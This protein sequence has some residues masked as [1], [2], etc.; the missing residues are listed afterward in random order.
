MKTN[1][2]GV[3]ARVKVAAGDLVQIDEVHSG[4]GYQSHF[5]SR[6]Y[7]GFGKRDESIAWRSVGSAAAWMCSRTLPWTVGS[8]SPRAKA[9]PK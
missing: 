1:R 2:D 3:G 8:R 4:R 7:F 6:L 9:K 5:G